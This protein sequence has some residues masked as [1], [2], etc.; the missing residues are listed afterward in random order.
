MH[1]VV[2]EERMIAFHFEVVFLRSVYRTKDGCRFIA[3]WALFS[4][5]LGS[6]F[7]ISGRQSGF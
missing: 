4:M 2:P 3:G 5:F 7:N 1:V 6:I